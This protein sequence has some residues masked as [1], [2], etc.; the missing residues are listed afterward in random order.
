[1]LFGALVGQICPIHATWFSIHLKLTL[2]LLFRKARPRQWKISLKS[3]RSWS[4]KMT[5]KSFGEAP[6]TL[7]RY[8]E[9]GLR[10][11]GRIVRWRR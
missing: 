4:I 9:F 1:M 6:C 2:A 11:L 5:T 10:V 8:V 7:T 3:S